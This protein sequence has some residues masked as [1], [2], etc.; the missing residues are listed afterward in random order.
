MPAERWDGAWVNVG[1]WRPT[2]RAIVAGAENPK[3]EGFFAAIGAIASVPGF[4]WLALGYAAS[5]MM[6]AALPTWAPAFLQR[7]HDVALAQ[8]GAL[9]GPPAVIGGLAGTILSG[10]L[11]TRLI[12]RSGNRRAGLIVPIV[13]LPLAVPAF[14]V[15]LFAPSLP[16]V[17]VAIAVMNFMLA[18]SL[19]PCIA[20]AVSLV[21]PARRG[22]TSTLILIVQTL[23]AF[24]LAPLIIGVASDALTPIYGDEALRYSLGL[25]LVAPLLASLL[26]WVA[27]SRIRAS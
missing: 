16:I 7:S 25:M 22:L 2:P 13:A 15:F 4:G 21:P 1:Q 8:V 11:A 23:L 3:K 17:L 12:Q 18:S 19:G 27:R 5:H 14:A 10:M 20:L 9:V 26:I 6:P 24:A